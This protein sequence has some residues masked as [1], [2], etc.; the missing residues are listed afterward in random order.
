MAPPQIKLRHS[1]SFQGVDSETFDD[2]VVKRDRR[3]TVTDKQDLYDDFN[4][5]NAYTDAS[6]ANGVSQG[7]CDC[8]ST[9]SAAKD[10]KVT[11]CKCDWQ[12]AARETFEE[13]DDDQE[14]DLE[15]V[16]PEYETTSRGSYFVKSDHVTDNKMEVDFNVQKS[17]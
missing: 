14:C 11:D 15:S 4:M 6:S 10:N 5:L 3:V 7:A 9:L 12:M 2:I 13:D 1:S 16:E 8:T 17:K